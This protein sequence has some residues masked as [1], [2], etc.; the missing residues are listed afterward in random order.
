MAPKR[1]ARRRVTG[2]ILTGS[3]SFAH[4]SVTN[5]LW[6]AQRPSA[7]AKTLSP[8]ERKAWYREIVDRTSNGPM[9]SNMVATLFTAC[10]RRA[11][12]WRGYVGERGNQ[13]SDGRGP[14]PAMLSLATSATDDRSGSQTGQTAKFACGAVFEGA[15]T[16]HFKRRREPIESTGCNRCP[17]SLA[18]Q[19]T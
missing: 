3:L 9:S 4:T 8:F 7:G 19:L 15:V 10:Y 13:L 1:Y 17:S 5:G 16:P 14:L 2:R 11:L 12:M 6:V 18:V